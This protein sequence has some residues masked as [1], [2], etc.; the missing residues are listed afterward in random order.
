[1]ID[2]KDEKWL[3]EA[4]RECFGSND[5]TKEKKLLEGFSMLTRNVV[6]NAEAILRQTKSLW[7]KDPQSKEL[8]EKFDSLEKCLFYLE[9]YCREKIGRE[10]PQK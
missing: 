4:L 10:L 2:L 6:K 9:R 1:M 3:K 8:K 7:G 5:V